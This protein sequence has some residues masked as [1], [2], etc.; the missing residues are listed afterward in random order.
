MFRYTN[1][2][3]Y[4]A[5]FGVGAAMAVTVGSKGIGV[6]F[7]LGK[8]IAT[9]YVAQVVFVVV[10]LGSVVAIFRI[11]VRPFLPGGPGAVSHCLLHGIE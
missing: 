7:G 11:P 10:V 5:P 2:V 3:M 6:L 8:L 1:Y 9:M 4:A